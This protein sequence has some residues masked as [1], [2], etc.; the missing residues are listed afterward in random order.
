M[1]IKYL[2]ALN[3]YTK[4]GPVRFK[5]LKARF[6]SWQAAFYAG[7]SEL[8][9]AGIDENIALDFI[10]RRKAIN[11]DAIMEEIIREKISLITPEDRRYPGILKEI[12]DFPPLLYLRGELKT[13]DDFSLAVVGARKFS[14]YG[15]RLT[16][17][18]VRELARYKI[19]IVSGLAL[20]IDALAHSAALLAGGRTIGVLGSGVDRQS[21]YP[22]ANQN[23]A[24]KIIAEG[25]AIISEFPLGTPGLRHH[26]PQRNRIIAGLAKGVLV[27]EAG[28]KSG[29]LIT[30]RFA[31]DFNREV[32]AVPGS[33]YSP[34]SAGANAL[35]KEGAILTR[36][37]N[38]IIEALD[39]KRVSLYIETKSVM[40]ET[41][42]EK[43]LLSFLSGESVHVNELIRLSGLPASTV[44]GSLTIM[45]MKGMIKNLGG[46]EYVLV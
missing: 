27:I 26:F 16:E 33:V 42:E 20:G 45:E 28:E 37:G 31:L 10:S 39:L 23:I 29:S 5:K 30:A 41:K 6:P 38:D 7:V 11:P 34:V 12:P 19:T 14:S 21:V 32:F 3:T 8:K 36:N 9:S 13:E 24:E 35:I 17:D 2:A 44:T 22:V 40:P 46:M 43:I 15:K 25:G 4:F 1:D 18:I